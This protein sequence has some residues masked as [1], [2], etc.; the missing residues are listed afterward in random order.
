[1][2]LCISFINALNEWVGKLISW[3]TLAMVITTFS[4]VVLRYLFDSGW[5]ALQESVTYMH[6]LVFML[7]AAYTLKHD[8]HVRVD[9]L[10]QRFSPKTR[11]IIDALGA[12]LLLLPVSGFIIWSSWHYV[13]ESWQVLEGSRHSGGLPGLFLLKSC[14]IAMAVLLILQGIAMFLQNLMI[15][16]GNDKEAL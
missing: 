16:I 11:A 1:M 14:I 8:G 13:S 12:L 2:S 4:V 7:G 6:S 15:V 5:I 10:Y 9:I 3:L